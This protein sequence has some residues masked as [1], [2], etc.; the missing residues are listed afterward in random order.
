MLSGRKAV[1]GALGL[2]DSRTMRH[3]PVNP[4][5]RRCARPPQMRILTQRLASENDG[6]SSERPQITSVKPEA[7][8]E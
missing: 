7:Y 6:P 4:V 3:L 2:V 8:F 1:V 5:V